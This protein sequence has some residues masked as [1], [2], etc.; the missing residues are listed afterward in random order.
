MISKYIYIIEEE[1]IIQPK[2]QTRIETS[3][4]RCGDI[5]TRVK[6]FYPIKISRYSEI[7]RQFARVL[8][9][10]ISLPWQIKK[11][12]Y[13]TYEYHCILKFFNKYSVNFFPN[14]PVPPVIKIDL[15]L[16]I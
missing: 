16:N 10:T 4:S 15:F 2:C 8:I 11:P 5:M 3:L 9:K 6:F 13:G 7:Q 14:D 1:V 12:F